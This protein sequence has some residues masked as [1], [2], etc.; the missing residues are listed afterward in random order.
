M[1]FH[2]SPSY[3]ARPL[4][5]RAQSLFCSIDPG[6]T[7]QYRVFTWSR[8]RWTSW[9]LPFWITE[10]AKSP[11]PHVLGQ[12]HCREAPPSTTAGPSQRSHLL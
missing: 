10:K 9:A 7:P 12:A 2:V 3:W 4:Q 5:D 11:L 8:Q 6:P 1:C